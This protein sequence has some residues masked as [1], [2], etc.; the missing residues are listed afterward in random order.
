MGERGWAMTQQE[1]LAA[2]DPGPMLE[3]MRGKASDRKLRLFACACASR[4]LHMMSD[5]R[6]RRFVE[7]AERFADDLAGVEALVAAASSAGDHPA[8]A[9]DAAT[10]PLRN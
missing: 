6:F 2:T 5:G 1:W 8:D 9:F 7:V 10:Y 3:F 4:N